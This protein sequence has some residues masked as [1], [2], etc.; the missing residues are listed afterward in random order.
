VCVAPD[1][2]PP[3]K[4]CIPVTEWNEIESLAAKNVQVHCR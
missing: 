1:Y 3:G 4:K 2:C